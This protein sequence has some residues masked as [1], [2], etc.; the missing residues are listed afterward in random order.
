MKIIKYFFVGASAACLDLV[1]FFIFAQVLSFNYLA[2]A[3][4]GFVLATYLNYLLSIK[5]VFN[6]GARF[7]Q[8][9]EIIAI[10]GVSAIGLLIN[11]T[12]LSICIEYF[13]IHKMISKITATFIVFLW[14]YFIRNCYIFKG[15]ELKI[16]Y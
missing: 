7:S 16:N 12:I 6:S 5:Y 13:F 3:T 8:K 2:V 10:F 1:I 15:K 11:V 9:K 14:N 4:F